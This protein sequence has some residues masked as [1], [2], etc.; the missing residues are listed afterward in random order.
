M[1]GMLLLKAV[2]M[3]ASVAFLGLA[4]R[5]HWMAKYDTQ[6]PKIG[7]AWVR[8]IMWI[9]LAGCIYAYY[10]DEV[11]LC[12]FLAFLGGSALTLD[13]IA[14]RDSMRRNS[15]TTLRRVK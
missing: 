11:L 14:L 12:G 4:L 8:G 10:A 3:A 2:S 6:P 7:S 13:L 9:A 1:N 5:I 15:N